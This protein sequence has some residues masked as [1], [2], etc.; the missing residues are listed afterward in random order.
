[1]DEQFLDDVSFEELISENN[2]A[3]LQEIIQQGNINAFDENESTM[4]YAA[5]LLEREDIVRMLI[6]AGA[7]LNEDGPGHLTS[8]LLEAYKLKNDK[9]LNMLIDG[10]ANLDIK[11]HPMLDNLERP[12]IQLAINDGNKKLVSK[13]LVSGANPDATD[14]Y[15]RTAL[16]NAI[17]KKDK[18]LVKMLIDSNINAEDMEGVTVLI[19]SLRDKAIFNMLVQAGIDLNYKNRWG[20]TALM[21]EVRYGS[22]DSIKSLIDAGADL[23]IQNS[24]GET[25]L[26]I[27]VHDELNKPEAP[28][29]ELLITAGALFENITNNKGKT[30]WD[31]AE[32]DTRDRVIVGYMEDILDTQMDVMKERTGR[33]DTTDYIL[34]YTGIS[35]P[36]KGGKR[37]KK[38]NYGKKKKSTRKHKSK[39]TTRARKHKKR[40]KQTRK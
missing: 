33:D 19:Y 23:N 34:Q 26:M 35:R 1:M 12:L 14:N 36:K 6:N 32:E 8:P 29:S 24:L 3:R 17:E 28:K 4:I 39:K 2:V 25:A 31:I 5:V 7:D 21:Y 22:L 13:L 30:A 27:A 9:I 11:D 38:R 15:R 18:E 40:S 20:E 37:T 16:M 10:G